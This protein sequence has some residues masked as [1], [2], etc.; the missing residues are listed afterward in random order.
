MQRTPT[1]MERRC[2]VA[3]QSVEELQCVVENATKTYISCESPYGIRSE[4]TD[5][6]PNAISI[7]LRAL[8]QIE[9]WRL[10]DQIIRVQSGILLSDLNEKLNQVGFEIPIGLGIEDQR[11]T[12]ASFL[13]LNVPH[14]NLS[15]GTWRDWITAIRYVSA[16]GKWVKSGADVVKSVTGFDLHKLLVGS[17]FTL[18]IPVSITLLVK[19]KK[20]TETY[21]PICL[22]QGELVLTKRSEALQNAT[23]RKDFEGQTLTLCNI[24]QAKSGSIWRSHQ[25]N[26]NLPE[27]SEVE[28]TWMR[29]LKSEF[30]P[31]SKLNPGA[32]GIF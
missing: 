11:H 25:A 8:N 14:W 22:N 29:K 16:E 2:M 6:E 23:Y 20:P 15:A 10:E 32:M 27:F 31:Q 7:D 9:D 26:N 1:E 21:P 4:A 19:P 13:S 24:H 12:L 17:R 3:P 5:S 30:D 28:K 18:G